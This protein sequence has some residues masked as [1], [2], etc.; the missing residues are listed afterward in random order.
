MRYRVPIIIGL[1]LALSVSVRAAIDEQKYRK[2]QNILTTELQNNPNSTKKTKKIVDDI[3]WKGNLDQ[4]YRLAEI[5]IGLDV[6]SIEDR[7]LATYVTWEAFTICQIV[8][9][10]SALIPL[11]DGRNVFYTFYS[12]FYPRSDLRTQMI[13]AAQ[14]LS[15]FASIRKRYSTL[16]IFDEPQR[17]YFRSLFEEED[18]FLKH[19][20]ERMLFGDDRYCLAHISPG[21]DKNTLESVRA[22]LG[23]DVLNDP[24]LLVERLAWLGSEKDQELLEKIEDLMIYAAHYLSSYD[25]TLLFQ[26]IAA[27]AI[28]EGVL[29]DTQERLFSM[30]YRLYPSQLEARAEDL[31]QLRL[32]IGVKE[33]MLYEFEQFQD[34]LRQQGFEFGGIPLYEIPIEKQAGEEWINYLERYLRLGYFICKEMTLRGGYD[35]IIDNADDIRHLLRV[36]GYYNEKYVTDDIR[37]IDRFI[38]YLCELSEGTYQ[39]YYVTHDAWTLGAAMTEYTVM[40]ALLDH[41]G[42]VR[43]YEYLVDA[44]DFFYSALNN[45]MMAGSIL[46]RY[47]FPVLYDLDMTGPHKD[48]NCY[49]IWFYAS[50]LPYTYR[51]YDGEQE[52][53]LGQYY[54]GR[55][56]EA[57]RKNK[58]CGDN[59]KA[60]QALIEYYYISEENVELAESLMEEFLSLTGDT[61]SYYGYQYIM[62]YHFHH[63]YVAAAQY[64]DFI[65]QDNNEYLASWY[66]D[67]SLSPSRVYALAGRNETALEQLDIFKI[68]MRNEIGKLLMGMGEEQASQMMKRYEVIND[69]FVILCGDTIAQ[70]LKDVYMQSFYDWQLQSK[71]MLLALNSEKD[72]LL[73]N[74]PDSNIRSLYE[75]CKQ[76]EKALTDIT[77]LSSQEA[78][79]IQ[80]NLM[81][82]KNNLQIAVQEYIDKNGFEGVNQTDWQDVRDALGE[83]QVAIEIVNGKMEDDTIPVYYALLLRSHSAAPEVIPMFSESDVRPLIGAQ[84]KDQIHATYSYEYRGKQ[85]SQLIWGAVLDHIEPG[86]IIFFSPSGLLHQVAI[87][88]L[89]YDATQTM[90]DRYNMVRLSSTR[91]IIGGKKRQEYQTATLYGGIRYGA[92]PSDL[93]SEHQKYK[94]HFKTP[95]LALAS[96][97][98]MTLRDRAEDLPGTEI[99]VDSI[100]YMLANEHIRVQTYRATN[101]TEESFKAL[102]GTRP[103][104]I[105][106][107]T[108]GFYW[109]EQEAQQQKFFTQNQ[110]MESDVQQAFPIDPLDRCGLLFA[111]ANTALSGHSNRLAKGVQDG[112]L[113]AKEIAALDLRGTDIVVLSACETGLGD[114]SGEGV[115]GLQRAF[116]MAGAQTMLMALWKVDDDATRML[117]T[118]FYRNY[119]KGQT[120]REAFRNAQQEVRD[121]TVTETKTKT[122]TIAAQSAASGKDK[123]TNKG[124]TAP[125]E[126]QTTSY[127]VTK[128]PYKSPFFWAGFVLLD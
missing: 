123:Y 25:Q 102:S 69:R 32:N 56:Y 95:E 98:R 105:H 51:L 49:N 101:A 34:S 43:M 26:Y 38:Y 82:A 92:S 73:A 14:M 80:Y 58:K 11:Q 1:F 70:E 20:I 40:S 24:T 81:Q 12:S 65:N 62:N 124:K 37:W 10:D 13:E 33:Q 61:A 78:M 15:A 128:Q 3:I 8:Q 84:N 125:T 47:L 119:S 42:H 31:V 121:Y 111:G 122:T 86:E 22:L 23:E 60:L 114:V 6:S 108:H 66:D 87:E 27:A 104:I 36:T 45:K 54:A 99:E 41:Q 30:L 90:S 39:W 5:W 94:E 100:E 75:R 113:T 18:S 29:D 116:K 89:P 126:T 52:T 115:F 83:H 2:Y 28:R 7:M 9:Q 74:H 109:Q 50:I 72:S 63:D 96:I 118:A 48:D 19:Y 120:K 103:N 4:L 76:R 107:A 106:L 112:I 117:T 55:L 21:P 97:Q 17:S 44:V 59:A 93:A 110:S 64:A 68:F 16:P 57:V 46:E 88:A 71:G 85:L 127:T 53:E 77:D 35:Y 91:E 79:I 67:Y